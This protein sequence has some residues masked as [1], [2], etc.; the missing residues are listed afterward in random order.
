MF[1]PARPEDTPALM[2]L[3]AAT[4]VFK[5]YEVEV[6][7]E[8]LDEF[9]AGRSGDEHAAIVLEEGGAILGYAYYAPDIMTDR[10]WHLYWIAVEKGG[11]GKG[12]GSR[13]MAQVE[14]D[15]RSRNGRM[16]FIETSSMP[17][18]E[19]TRKFYLKMGYRLEARLRDF[20]SDG[21]DLCV[22]RKRLDR[23]E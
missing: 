3:T 1:R 15:V 19:L 18:S 2:A 6:L 5:P 22:F 11:Q 21:D 20:Y 4:G 10:S 14:A 8:V 9:H 13:L 17:H 7:K 23:P 16:M 12:A